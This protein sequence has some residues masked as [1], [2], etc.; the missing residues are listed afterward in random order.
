M[1]GVGVTSATQDKILEYLLKELKKDRKRREKIV[2]F[3]P[4]PEQISAAN[5]DPKLAG[6]LNRAQIALPDGI[7]TV[8]GSRL[9]G[10]PIQARIPGID[11]MKSLCENISKW[12]VNTGYFGGQGDVAEKAGECLRKMYPGLRVEY[13]SGEV[14]S[15]ELI[16][17][18]I[19]ILFVGLGFPKQEQWIL[20]NMNKIPATVFMSVGGSFD[21][22]SG[23]IPRAP[24]FL[25]R[26]GLEWLFRLIVQPW[27]FK[28]QL[29]ILHFG[30]LIFWKALSNRLIRLKI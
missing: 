5:C 1:L 29:Q 27:R 28:R 2:I 10:T 20:E 8:L 26:V 24:V 22:L 21:F 6:V 30:G 16:R 9:I 4:N 23:R 25:R 13:A 12:P 18:D 19:D 15:E 11:F 17:S 3:T 14:L 7:G